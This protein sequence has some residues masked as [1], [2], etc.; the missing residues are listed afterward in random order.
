[1]AMPT[2]RIPTSDAREFSQ[3][4]HDDLAGVYMIVNERNAL[5]WSISTQHRY[6]GEAEP[7][8]PKNL[9]A[10]IRTKLCFF[11]NIPNQRTT[12][13]IDIISLVAWKRTPH[14]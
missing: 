7:R 1:M 4:V 10:P 2:A 9:L 5:L 12:G 8:R 3:I 13:R 11:L 6:S 14:Q